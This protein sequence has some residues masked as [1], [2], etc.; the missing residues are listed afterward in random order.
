VERSPSGAGTGAGGDLPH[1]VA[2]SLRRMS[3]AYEAAWR[4]LLAAAAAGAPPPGQL[5][6][7]RELAGRVEAEAGAWRPHIAARRRALREKLWRGEEGRGRGGRSPRRA[8]RQQ[9]EAAALAAAAA[10]LSGLGPAAAGLRGR[11]SDARRALRRAEAAVSAAGTSGGGAPAAS[12][13]WLGLAG[14]L[15][16]ALG[17]FMA[18]LRD[19]AERG[20]AA[21]A[22]AASGELPPEA[23]AAA[24]AAAVTAA[25][26]AARP[27]RAGSLAGAAVLAVPPAAPAS[28]RPSSPFAGVAATSGVGRMLLDLP[29]PSAAASPRG[30]GGGR[31]VSFG[32]RLSVRLPGSGDFDADQV[33]SQALAAVQQSPRHA[34]PG[35]GVEGGAAPPPRSAG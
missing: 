23:A 34:G 24:V 12:S 20:A 8:A 29:A 27:A 2:A 11:L 35:V 17:A 16:D 31:S 30:P 6:P 33:P 26:A 28:P 7:L 14:P 15:L 10:A 25:G 1:A 18:R 3:T 5:L 19:A 4:G 32:G 21:A 22:A 13:A 9:A